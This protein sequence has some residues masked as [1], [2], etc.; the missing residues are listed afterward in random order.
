MRCGEIIMNYGIGRG[1]AGEG[2]GFVAA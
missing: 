2:T 1:L